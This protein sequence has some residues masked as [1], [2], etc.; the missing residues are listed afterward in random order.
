MPHD[1]NPLVLSTFSNTVG[2]PFS[3]KCPQSAG[4]A[5]HR[6]LKVELR[7]LRNAVI[8]FRLL[9]VTSSLC[10]LKKLIIMGGWV[11]RWKILGEKIRLA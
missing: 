3:R 5:A 7:G 11:K 4:G 10:R 1:Q 2:F 8:F 6:R 9:A